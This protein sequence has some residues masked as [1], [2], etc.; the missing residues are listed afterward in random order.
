MET[1][2]FRLDLSNLVK[3]S[4]IQRCLD[5]NSCWIHHL[6]IHDVE[7][8]SILESKCIFDCQFH[9]V[10]FSLV[11]ATRIRDRGMEPQID[12]IYVLDTL[13]KNDKVK[14]FFT[15]ETYHVIDYNQEWEQG[16]ENPLFPEYRASLA[17]F[18]NADSNTTTGSYKLGDVET[19]ALMTV[20]FKTMPYANNKYNLSEPFLIYDLKASITHE[21]NVHEEHLIKAEEVLKTKKI[22][23]T[24]H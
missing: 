4:Q 9:F 13:F 6:L 3:T 14:E 22:F 1:Q 8:S 19:G 16:R 18:F 15:P 5:Q 21:G 10:F 7:S 23:V 20:N 2:S 17:K 24:W 11:T 12:E